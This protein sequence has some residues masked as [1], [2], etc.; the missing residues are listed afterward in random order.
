MY[1]LGIVLYELLTGELP[2]TGE[3]FVAIAMRHINE[4]PPSVLEKRPD[5]PVRVAAAVDRA[6]EKKPADRFPT[7]TAFADELTEC[8]R[9]V[10]FGEG[11]EQTGVLAPPEPVRGRPKARTAARRARD[12]PPSPA[13]RGAS[14]CSSRCS[15]AWRSR[16]AWR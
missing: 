7:M 6:L 4:A 2:F 12:A 11:G 9:E 3:N 8:L 10:R 14:S 13:C 15:P 5:V 16:P 1:S